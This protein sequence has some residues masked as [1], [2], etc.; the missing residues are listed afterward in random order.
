[1]SPLSFISSPSSAAGTL[2]A[3]QIVAI[4]VYFI[5]P[6]FLFSSLP[7]CSQISTKIANTP[8]KLAQMQKKQ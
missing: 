3:A 4:V 1:L 5:P 6:A 8:A 7:L 2:I